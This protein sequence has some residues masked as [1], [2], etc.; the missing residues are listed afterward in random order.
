MRSTTPSWFRDR[1]PSCSG[2]TAESCPLTGR[3]AL[4]VETGGGVI[5]S[6][7]VVDASDIETEMLVQ[8]GLP[9]RSLGRPEDPICVHDLV[10]RVGGYGPGR[11]K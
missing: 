2:W 9:E 4:R 8:F 6:G 10:C 11:R 1:T 5:V 7:L 3:T